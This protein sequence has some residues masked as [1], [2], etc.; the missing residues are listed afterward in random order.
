[1]FFTL[2]GKMGKELMKKFVVMAAVICG[3]GGCST[4]SDYH[5]NPA[6][7]FSGLSK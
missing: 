5:M 1:M 2:S 6:D 7:W 3:L 4:L